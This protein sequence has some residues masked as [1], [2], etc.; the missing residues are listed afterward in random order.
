MSA[1]IIGK[2]SGDVEAGGWEASGRV[3]NDADALDFYQ[4][5]LAWFD[6]YAGG[7]SDAQRSAFS[8]HLLPEAWKRTVQ[9]SDAP[10]KAFTAQEFMK[11]GELQGIYFQDV[12]SSPANRHQII[13]MTFAAIV[14]EV[15]GGHCNL[16]LADDATAY[17]STLWGGSFTTPTFDD[18][19]LALNLDF[20]NSAAVD[21][22]A[23]KDGKFWSRLKEIATAEFYQLYVDKT[24]T[25]NY[26]PHPMFGASV[27]DIVL[28]LDDGLLLEP[29]TIERRNTE[30]IGQ[31]VLHGTTPGGTQITGTYPADPNPGPIMR[32]GGYMLDSATDL[33]AIAQRMYLFETRGYTVTAEIG[34]G[35]GLLLELLER[36]AI[37]YSSAQDGI[38]WSSKPFYVHKID[39][40]VMDGFTAKTRLVLEQENQVPT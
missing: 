40:D 39:V 32:R 37:T 5:V 21:S 22:Y 34:N 26:V 27:P 35:V 10:W 31:M 36:V 23:F 11:Q 28:T 33:D 8:G 30:A 3:L 16:V 15:L 4:Q 12:A 6:L 24:N 2:I 9:G 29:L 17:D 14:Y 20:T 13:D 1:N 7:W 18:G 38:S 25:L 19:F